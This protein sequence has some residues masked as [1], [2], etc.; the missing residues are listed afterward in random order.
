MR[1]KTST[2]GNRDD[3]PV[4]AWERRAKE[5]DRRYRAS[6]APHTPPVA[7]KR[8]T[9]ETASTGAETALQETR[10]SRRY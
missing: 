9:R 1:T 4:V 3:E 5:T 8:L 7:L 2:H 10:A 6:D